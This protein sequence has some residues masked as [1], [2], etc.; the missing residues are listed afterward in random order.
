[1][2]NKNIFN[3]KRNIITQE[4]TTINEAGGSAYSL[5]PEHELAQYAVTG[6]FNNTFYTS[7]EDQLSNVK[8]LLNKIQD[9]SFIGKVAMYAR[10]HGSMKDVPAFLVA[11]LAS[12][13]DHISQTV[14]HMVFP[15][16]INDG[17][18]LRNFVQMMRS[19]VVGR[20]SLGS[21][22]K[23]AVANW[24]KNRDGNRI[25]TN[26]IGNNPSFV[27]ILKLAHVRPMSKEHEATFAYIMGKLKDEGKENLNKHLPSLIVDF[28]NFKTGSEIVPNIPFQFLSSLDLS[29]SAWKEIAKN[30]SWQTLRMNLNTFERHG[31]FND[32]KMVK[33]VAN[34]LC[35][36]EE[37]KN[38]KV[39]PYQLYVAYNYFKGKHVEI[40]N[41]LQDALDCSLDNIPSFGENVF[42]CPDVSG[43][44][45]SPATGDRGSATSVVRCID[46]AALLASAILRKNQNAKVIPFENEVVN[47]KLNSRDSVMT[48]AQ[49]LASIHGG[50]TNCSAALE[51]IIRSGSGVDTII[52]ISD[53]QS[54]MDSG[55]WG[56]K[57]DYGIG[58][59]GTLGI[60]LFG[61]I[62]K[63]NPNAKMICIDIQPYGSTQ[64]KERKDILNIG[65]FNDS[66]FNVIDSF[67]SVGE[68]WVDLIK[69]MEI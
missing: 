13:P 22:S 33:F 35:D 21:M 3:S 64:F 52:Y 48:N 12:R 20:N 68:N 34:R 19:G 15:V 30:C 36:V 54:W 38:A 24:F 66:V 14:F 50:G 31:V 53:N 55:A 46:V 39:F 41:A 43:S 57:S 49:K 37:I 44:M 17:R 63:K 62:K 10:K 1:M 69:A 2:A 45:G 29:E 27:D 8:N 59:R 65:G 23:K 67:V 18:M 11:Y 40:E 9:S 7:A 16:V 32:K 42:V 47:I 61:S 6:V 51:E 28:E 58:L 60:N 56:G 25:F 4:T 26:S 5:T